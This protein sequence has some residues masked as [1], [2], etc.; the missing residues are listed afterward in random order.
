MRLHRFYISEETSGGKLKPQTEFSIDS[1]E[2][3]N[4]IRRVFRLKN[5]DHVILFDGSGFDFESEIVGDSDYHGKKFEGIT[6]HILSSE[7]SPFMP[8]EDLYLCAAITKKDTFEWTVAKATELGATDIIPIL[9]E[10]SEKKAL[11][12]DRLNKISI[13]ASEQSGRGDVLNI[14][15]IMKLE[16]AIIAVKNMQ[17]I[18]FHVDAEPFVRKEFLGDENPAEPVPLAVFIGP[19]GGWSSD[20]IDL[21]HKRNIPVRCLGDQILRAET[22]VVAALSQVA[23]SN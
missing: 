17:A 20:E 18:A 3:T 8:K 19:E 7:R 2:L 4:Q 21:F 22:A 13:E 14:S 9:S 23:F 5:G 10:R 11:N 1:A 15:L 6:F 12:M 16:E